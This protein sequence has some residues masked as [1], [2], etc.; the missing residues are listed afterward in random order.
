MAS[1]G[2]K[3]DAIRSYNPD[4]RPYTPAK[5]RGKSHLKRNAK[6]ATSRA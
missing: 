6:R 1:D 4:K 3:G 2:H 5:M